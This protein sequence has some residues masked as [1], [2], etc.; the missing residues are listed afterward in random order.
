MLKQR[1]SHIYR[2][3]NGLKA[4][5][6]RGATELPRIL[7]DRAQFLLFAVGV[8]MLA[9]GSVSLA[10]AQ[11][12]NDFK[13][14]QA[15]TAIFTYIEGTFGALVMVAA[16][17]GAIL[18]S[19]FGQYRASLSLL[20]VAVGAFILRSLVHTFFNTGSLPD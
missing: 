20:V 5:F 13:I 3:W 10:E 6:T 11:E 14:V 1:D 16:G 2:C 7:Q 15:L 17:I 4:Y 18:S 8:V 9:G 19:A 12:F